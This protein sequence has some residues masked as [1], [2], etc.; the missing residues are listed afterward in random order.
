MKI[1]T[2]QKFSLNHILFLAYFIISFCR[3]RLTNEIFNYEPEKSGY[4][5][6]MFQTILSHSLAIIP[7]MFSKY[8]SKRKK[9]E[10]QKQNENEGIIEYIYYK[11]PFKGR[12][13]FKSTLLVSVFDFSAE[14]VIFLFYFI[15]NKHEVVYF[16]SLNSYLKYSYA[17]FSKLFCT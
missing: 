13:I 4:F 12:N 9:D 14:A 7:F 17:I 1:I 3:K 6:L 5:F 15:N 10:K 2:F 11:N 16:Y 8:L